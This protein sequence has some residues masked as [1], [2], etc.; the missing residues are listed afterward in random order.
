M[1]KEYSYCDWC[2]YEFE[3][4][5]GNERYCSDEHRD[6]SRKF[7]QGEKYKGISSLLPTLNRNHVLLEKLSH[8]KQE[9]FTGAE[10][11][12]EGL[13]FSLFRRLYPEPDDSTWIRLD[14]GTFYLDT[15]DNFKT[16]KL[17]KHE[18]TFRKA[19]RPSTASTRE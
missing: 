17:E 2:G 1:E 13:D 10:L 3:L 15:K 18:T 8:R 11:E 9:I 19:I 16:Y 6:L 14:F 7:R 4:E 5:H 12:S